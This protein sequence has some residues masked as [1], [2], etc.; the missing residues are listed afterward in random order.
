LLKVA[1][2]DIM[3]SRPNVARWYNELIERPSWKAV[4]GGV[5]ST[6]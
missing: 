5:K 6:A 3:T 2:S 1:G 4:V